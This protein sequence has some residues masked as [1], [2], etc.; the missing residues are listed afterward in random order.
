MCVCKSNLE[1][2]GVEVLIVVTS[3]HGFVIASAFG[4]WFLR[5]FGAVSFVGDCYLLLHYVTYI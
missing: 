1:I 4:A 5:E 3:G 2:L